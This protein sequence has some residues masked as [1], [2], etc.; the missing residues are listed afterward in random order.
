MKSR[1]RYAA[2]LG[3]LALA[4]SAC[5]EK[6]A[7]SGAA[8]PPST[9]PPAETTLVDPAKLEAADRPPLSAVDG[10]ASAPVL[11]DSSPA[12]PSSTTVAAE[13]P[14][15]AQTDAVVDRKTKHL[16]STTF[17]DYAKDSSV[18]WT[19]EPEKAQKSEI[20]LA[21]YLGILR[22]EGEFLLAMKATD[23]WKTVRDKTLACTKELA[24][25]PKYQGK[26]TELDKS[27]GALSSPTLAD[28]TAL[29][30]GA[31]AAPGIRS[32]ISDQNKDAYQAYLWG[33]L[34]AGQRYQ[35][36]IT[37]K[38][39]KDATEVAAFLSIWSDTKLSEY[40]GFANG[41]SA[42]AGAIQPLALKSAVNNGIEAMI[43]Y[44][45]KVEDGFNRAGAERVHDML[46]AVIDVAQAPVVAPE[47]AEAVKVRPA[48]AV[49]PEITALIARAKKI[50]EG[51]ASGNI[52]MFPDPI[53]KIMQFD[54]VLPP[55][56]NKKEFWKKRYDNNSRDYNPSDYTD[57]AVALPILFGIRL[58]DGFFAV[59]IEDANALR[60][61]AEDLKAVG[62]ELG[63]KDDDLQRADHI[64]R[65]A[66][67]NEWVKVV[68]ELT[69]LREDVLRI[70]G[71]AEFRKSRDLVLMGA[72]IQ[73]ASYVCPA[74]V[75]VINVDPQ[76]RGRFSSIL[77]EPDMVATSIYG[78]LQLEEKN[79]YHP[80]VLNGLGVL[81]DAH[82]TVNIPPRAPVTPL[83][84]VSELGKKS[85]EFV[86]SCI[87]GLKTK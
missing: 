52:L 2:A 44:T 19:M 79:L 11:T 68:T 9:A 24:L 77:R 46:T 7:P 58:C 29:T 55:N 64:P 66:E 73:A 49:G 37:E 81:V 80:I 8:S 67:N 60:R 87:E 25:I 15:A 56:V 63:G 57:K 12:A 20:A 32:V 54:S 35:E 30:K 10:S 70:L 26:F 74:V 3:Y 42:T 28:W 16:A 47:T 61:V 78:V 36:W 45:T 65:L 1:L 48:V 76:K 22:T 40:Q 85:S 83:E 53:D 5:K 34:L 82:A 71:K 69:F 62:K 59:Q 38:S 6:S 41:I 23:E 14:A 86:D 17:V 4:L 50:T 51:N 84:K 39:A 18:A 33:Q 72:W 21:A 31:A 75:D 43:A 13:K 27:I